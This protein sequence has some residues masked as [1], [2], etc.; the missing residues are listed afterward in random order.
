MPVTLALT[1][2]EF[3]VIKTLVE[4]AATHTGDGADADPTIEILLQHV[5]VDQPESTSNL[6]EFVAKAR[7]ALTRH[8]RP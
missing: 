4:Y 7:K 8:A 3:T 6:A 5:S 2:H 1:F